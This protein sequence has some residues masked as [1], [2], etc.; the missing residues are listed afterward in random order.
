MPLDKQQALDALR[1][2]QD[3]TTTEN[4]V[5]LGHVRALAACDGYIS[6]TVA[7]PA[8]DPVREHLRSV[9][10]AT[11]AEASAK[12]DPAAGDGALKQ[13]NIEFVT[14]DTPGEG[15]GKDERIVEQPRTVSLKQASSSKT[16][17]D[18]TTA[19][20]SSVVPGAQKVIAVGAGKGGVGK[21]TVAVN[22][23]VGL[24][25]KGFDVGVLDADIY[26]PSLPTLLGLDAL[27]VALHKNRLQTFHVHGVRAMTIG[28]LVDPE[29]PLIWRGPMAHGAFKQLAEQTDWGKL[30]YLIVDLPPGT[31]DVPLTMS[32]LLSLTGAIVVC[33]PQRVA[34]DDAVRAVRMFQQLKIDVLG[35]VEN[36]SYFIGDDGVEYDIFGRGGAEMMAQRLGLPF[37][38][39]LP[40]NMPLRR[41]SDGGQPLMNF[42]KGVTGELLV[43]QL[44]SMVDQAEVQ[45]NLAGNRVSAARPTLTVS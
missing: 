27:D 18:G 34:Q 17:E 26:G 40:L 44:T 13:L 15:L 29:K 32:Q 11:L 21:S 1:T 4:L 12:V 16:V 31:G 33:T 25:R 30:D 6:V 10:Q 9:V 28:K 24:A 23:A 7:A 20:G 38:G 14:P 2:I 36:M 22:L 45:A 41:H 35:I 3:A 42:E 39:A 5:S 8:D 43:R 37:L 19:A